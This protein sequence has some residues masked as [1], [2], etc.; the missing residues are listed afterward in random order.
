MVKQ[1]VGV[2]ASAY[3]AALQ[4]NKALVRD[5]QRAAL[6][7]CNRSECDRLFE[8]WQSRDCLEAATRYLTRKQ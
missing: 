8:R 7:A 3:P 6:K 2:V 5:P 4:F 1:R